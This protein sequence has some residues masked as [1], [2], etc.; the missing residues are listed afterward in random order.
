MKPTN[1]QL[2][3]IEVCVAHLAR[4]SQ[5]PQRQRRKSDLIRIGRISFGDGRRKKVETR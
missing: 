5:A 1:E 4:N 2:E 3:L